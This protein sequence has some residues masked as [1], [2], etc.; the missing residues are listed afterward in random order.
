MFDYDGFSW[1]ILIEWTVIPVTLVMHL[2]LV[3][4][5]TLTILSK[6][7]ARSWEAITTFQI[8]YFFI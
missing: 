6:D 8:K 4:E 1:C 3:N 7:K 2:S 5:L